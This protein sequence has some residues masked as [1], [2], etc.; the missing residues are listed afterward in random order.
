M[1][2][3]LKATKSLSPFN[4]F[5]FWLNTLTGI[6]LFATY[7]SYYIS[8][9]TTTI[10]A[11]LALGFPFL[12][13]GNIL[14][15]L[16]WLIKR[17]KTFLFSLV[18]MSL[19]LYHLSRFLQVS[20]HEEPTEDEISIISYNVRLFDLYNWSNNEETRNDILQFLEDENPGIICFQEYFYSS[21]NYFNTRDTLIQILDAKNYVEH[22]TDSVNEKRGIGSK[23]Y[24]GSAIY[25]KYPI[26]NSGSITFENDHSN[27]A[28]WADLIVNNDT[29]RV[30]NAHL[31]S[32]RFQP[33]DYN[34]IGGKGNPQKHKS[35]KPQNILG[36]LKIGFEKRVS[37]ANNVIQNVKKS[38][39]ATILCSDMNDT[40]ISYTYNQ[41][42]NIL[43]DCFTEEGNGFGSTYIGNYPFLRIDYIWH[44]DNFECSSFITHNVDH[45]DHRP[46]QAFLRVKQ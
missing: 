7:L 46:V 24:F 37:Q 23:S 31:G 34:I 5:I 21:S 17:K 20:I 39:F 32:I 28:M 29:V 33:A 14:F 25:S 3:Y 6:L 26:V 2:F 10:F 9:E 15:I 27:H 19:G 35:V 42:S 18:I 36:R 44:D 41:F 12:F 45:S 8:P 11:L 13:F 30:F 40:P 1:I 43:Y 38:P 4:R 16:Y 22:F